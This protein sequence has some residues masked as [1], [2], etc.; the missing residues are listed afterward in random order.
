MPACMLQATRYTS[1]RLIIIGISLIPG[2]EPAEEKRRKQG[3]TQHEANPCL[4]T[5][6]RFRGDLSRRINACCLMIFVKKAFMNS[7][8][9]EINTSIWN[10]T[11]LEIVLDNVQSNSFK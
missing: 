9:I 8:G 3:G 2:K 1:W 4:F 7:G 11:C 10:I 6:W 5:S